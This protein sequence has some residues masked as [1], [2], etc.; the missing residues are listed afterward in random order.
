MKTTKGFTLIE[1]MVALAILAV[2]LGVIIKGSSE[3]TSQLSY[4]RDK[5]Y[6]WFVAENALTRLKLKTGFPAMGTTKSKEK[7]AGQI[8]Y[9][10]QVVTETAA[11]DILGKGQFIGVRIEVKKNQDDETP[12][13]KLQS[14]FSRALSR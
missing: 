4:L 8:W 5:T 1:I 3:Q 13:V 2:T 12:L 6:A 10:E 9:V 14:Y 11:Q 7:M